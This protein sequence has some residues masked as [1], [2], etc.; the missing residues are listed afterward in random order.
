M[1]DRIVVEDAASLL[2]LSSV[3]EED[4]FPTT[5]ENPI[6][7]RV[8]DKLGNESDLRRDPP[9]PPPQP[10]VPTLLPLGEDKLGEASF[11]EKVPSGDFNIDV[12]DFFIIFCSARRFGEISPRG[13]R[14][15]EQLLDERVPPPLRPGDKLLDA[16]RDASAVLAPPLRPRPPLLANELSKLDLIGLHVSSFINIL[17][18]SKYPV[19][20]LDEDDDEMCD[21]LS[22]LVERLLPPVAAPVVL[23]PP[24][25][26]LR[27][28]PVVVLRPR[29]PPPLV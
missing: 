13:E 20:S 15:G 28:P 16:L 4:V 12:D 17:L 24:P 25:V 19:P 26:V 18:S 29:D 27:P 22:G 3:V 14:D 1:G 10:L 2:I 11:N 5:G 21:M 7:F 8:E 23:R 9:P 6:L